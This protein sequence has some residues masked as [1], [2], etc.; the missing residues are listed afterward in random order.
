MPTLLG[1]ELMVWEAWVGC[2]D[3]D[4]AAGRA[5]GQ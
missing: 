3:R 4:A 5:Q 1:T 2:D